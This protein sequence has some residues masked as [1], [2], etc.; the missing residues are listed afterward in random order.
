MS[1]RR[2]I[3]GG[4]CDSGSKAYRDSLAGTPERSA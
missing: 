1:I 2:G 4:M 3:R